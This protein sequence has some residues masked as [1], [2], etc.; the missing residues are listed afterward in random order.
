MTSGLE[1]VSGTSRL[2]MIKEFLNERSIVLPVIYA[3]WERMNEERAEK[4]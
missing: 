3:R 1:E 2:H 4:R